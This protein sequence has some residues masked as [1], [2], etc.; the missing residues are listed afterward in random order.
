MKSENKTNSEFQK[1]GNKAQY[2]SNYS[3]IFGRRC[4]ICQGKGYHVDF[5]RH[6]KEIHTT[7]LICQGLGRRAERYGGL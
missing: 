5:D 2:D 6:G 1:L 3:K 4:S 7:C